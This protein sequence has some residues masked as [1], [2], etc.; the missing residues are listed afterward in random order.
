M[1]DSKA[2]EEAAN[3]PAKDDNEATSLMEPMLVSE[4]PTHR[5]ALTDLVV[6][7]AIK[8]H[9]QSGWFEETP[10]KGANTSWRRLLH[11]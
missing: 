6:E 11:F 4:S 7:L 3:I 9:P 1:N 2:A 10:S 8:Y 5:T